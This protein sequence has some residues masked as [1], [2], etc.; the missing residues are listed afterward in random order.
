MKGD[1]TTSKEYLQ[2]AADLKKNVERD[3]WNDSLKHFTDRYKQNNEF[4]HYWDFIRGRELAGFAPWYFNLP[5][6][7]ST[8][9]AAWRHAIDTS[10]L[11]GQFGLRTNEPSYQYYFKQFTYSFGQRGSQWNGPSWPYQTSQ[12]ITSMANFLN[13]YKQNVIT[14]SDYIKLLR[15]FTQQHYLPNG[16]I[17]LVENYDP[18]LGGPIVYY[19]W[20][21]HYNHSSYNN[22]IISGLCGIRPSAGDTL[23]INPLVDTSIKYFCIDDVRYHGHQLTV[24]Y[25]N[26]GSKYNLGKGITVFIDGK[27]TD[28]IQTQNKYEVVVGAPVIKNIT[29]QPTDFALNILHTGYPSP[30][31]S[32]NTNPDSS[33]YQA[34]DGRIWYFSEITN[35]WTTLGSQS[36]TDWYAIDFGQ[37]REISSAKIYLYADGKNFAPPDQVTVEYQNGAAW[38]PVKLKSQTPEK[39]IGN[40]VNS[41]VFD[42]ISTNKIRINFKHGSKTVA[43]SEVECY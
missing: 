13:N 37:P 22:L 40:T 20:S 41:I 12:A 36:G 27:K 30:S 29:K 32:C 7:T 28:L 21:N 43:V 11:L 3:L 26:D 34:I 4:V 6:D 17:D 38:L 18:N 15:L 1:E 8:Y 23:L 10:Q 9:N 2:K 19:Y 5:T 31:A 24:V 14:T 35:R 39:P 42:K 33:L 16:K 25:D